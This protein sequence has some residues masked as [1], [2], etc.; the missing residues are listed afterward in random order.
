MGAESQA[1]GVVL[2]AIANVSKVGTDT[3]VRN[4]VLTRTHDR[5][6]TEKPDVNTWKLAIL[7]CLQQTKGTLG[8][9]IDF[10]ILSNQ[11]VADTETIVRV[12]FQ[13]RVS[14]VQCIAAGVFDEQEGGIGGRSF[15]I[16]AQSASLEGVIVPAIGWEQ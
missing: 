6:G 14:F 13:D 2:R 15:R 5:T 4:E 11:T 8:E 7:K 12:H 9:A 1:Q 10:D 3:G 16:T